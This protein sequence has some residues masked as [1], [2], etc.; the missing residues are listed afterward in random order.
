MNFVI[1]NMHYPEFPE[2]LGIIRRVR[3]PTLEELLFDQIEKA[4]KLKGE[5]NLKKLLEK[6]SW[7]VLPS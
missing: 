2:P 6:N 1:A 3:E 4:K 7:E 5:G